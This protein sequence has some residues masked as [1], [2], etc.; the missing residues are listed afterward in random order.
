M[1]LYSLNK[2]MLVKLVCTMQEEH[3]KEIDFLKFVEKSVCFTKQ[4]CSVKGCESCVINTYSYGFK[5]YKCKYIGRC[6]TCFNDHC[7]KHDPKICEEE[8]NIPKIIEEMTLSVYSY[9]DLYVDSVHKFIIQ[10][11]E[12]KSIS[13]DYVFAPMK[14][15]IRALTKQERRIADSV[16]PYLFDKIYMNRKRSR[17]P[18]RY[19]SR[20]PE[21]YRSRS[22]E[23]YRSRSPGRRSRSP[24]R[25]SRSPERRSRSRSR[26]PIQRTRSP[27][28]VK[29]RSRSRSPVRYRSPVR[30]SRSPP[31]NLQPPKIREML[32][33]IDSMSDQIQDIIEVTLTDKGKIKE[34]K[35]GFIV[36]Q[37]K[38]GSVTAYKIDDG[39]G[40]E[41]DLDEEEKKIAIRMGLKVNQ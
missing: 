36:N 40:G 35:Y 17:S 5:Y 23:R 31:R 27:S 18:V 30:R 2:D 19:R 12:D 25:R 8:L 13:I 38:D 34:T 7:D 39:N 22:P 6:I 26:S 37:E 16:I 10:Y 41:K 29:Y 3:K 4:N 1:N 9:P 20:S 21:R 24:G 32:I 15:E 28:P 33:I 11:H 14:N